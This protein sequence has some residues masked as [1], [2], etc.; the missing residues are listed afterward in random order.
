MNAL[1]KPGD[2]GRGKLRKAP[3]RRKQPVIRGFPNGATHPPERV[4]IRRKAKANQGK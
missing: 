2:E 3:G 4:D 1:A